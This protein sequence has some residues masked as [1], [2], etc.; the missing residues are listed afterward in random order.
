MTVDGSGLGGSVEEEIW[1]LL[2]VD[3]AVADETVYLVAAALKGDQELADQLGDQASTI[4]RPETKHADATAPLRAF[5]RSITVSGFRGVGPRSTLEVNPYRGITV[6]SGRNGSGKS[7]FA[8]ALEYALTG[9][10]YRFTNKAKH[11]RDSWRNL[12]AGESASIEIDFA[13][14]P[15]GERDGSSAAIGAEWKEGAE[16]SD[17]RRWS[18]IRGEKREPVDSLGWN[19]ALITY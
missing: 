17:C 18:Q 2:D 5:L 6:I 10:S 14:E 1:G 19:Q 13:M 9:A 12:H 8:E 4:R 16:L 3:E 7:S 15:D 11:W